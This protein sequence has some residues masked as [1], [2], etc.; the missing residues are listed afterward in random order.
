MQTRTTSKRSL[1]WLAAALLLFISINYAAT[2]ETPERYP[3]YVSDSPSPTGIKA[4]YTYMDNQTNAAERWHH[5]P[6]LLE[7]QDNNRL[8]I[9]VEPSFI[10]ATEEMQNYIS[11]MESGNTILLLN[12]NPEGMFDI[13]TLTGQENS[14]SV[15]GQEGNEYA[16]DINSTFRL[17]T[18]NVD[19]V[20]LNDNV[21]AIAVEKT[22]EKGKLITAVAPEWITNENILE[23]DHLEL[24][25]SLVRS[26][27]EWETIYID[28]YIHS[29][30]NAPSLT[31]VYPDW[32]LVIGFQAILFAV[33]WLWFKGKRFGPM[34]IP[35]EETVR[36]SDERIQ[37]LA[38]WYQ[39]NKL[40]IDSL[41]GQADYVRLLLQERW[42]ISYHKDWSTIQEQL[43]SKLVSDLDVKQF[44]NGLLN[45]LHQRR[46]S[47]K[48]Y[49]S[50]SKKIDQL[51]K[52]VEEQ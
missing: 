41:Q 2:P 45:V 31:T 51:R 3:A 50:W 11:F 10:P 13:E 48:T 4:F 47:K 25:L 22:F 46:I 42:G 1:I 33:I 7:R 6:D 29:S 19:D 5:P 23:Q 32:L 27:T 20:L 15:M 28:E 37:A 39:K 9:M 34:V 35:R 44:I 17:D 40:Y 26:Q 18:N 12:T 30:K 36:F 38:A 43:E 8:L 16:A 52:E 21:G 24:I 49:V 14:G